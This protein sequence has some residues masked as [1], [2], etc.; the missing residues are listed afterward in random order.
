MFPPLLPIKKPMLRYEEKL[1]VF[2]RNNPL[3]LLSLPSICFL[4]F[5][6]FWAYSWLAISARCSELKNIICFSSYHPHP[7]RSFPYFFKRE[8]YWQIVGTFP[9]SL[10]LSLPPQMLTSKRIN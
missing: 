8:L 10:P 3:L 6:S 2:F 1:C 4:W 7:P 5:V 9:P